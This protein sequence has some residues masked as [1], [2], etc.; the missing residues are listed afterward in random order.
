MTEKKEVVVIDA[1]Q[2]VSPIGELNAGGFK[3]EAQQ[4]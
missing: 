2:L 1:G 3:Y 4:R